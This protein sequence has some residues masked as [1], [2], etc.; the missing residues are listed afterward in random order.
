MTSGEEALREFARLELARIMS[1][2]VSE[3]PRRASTLGDDDPVVIKARR[4][5]LRSLDD[6]LAPVVPIRRAAS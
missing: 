6:R 4:D 3:P 1:G 5:V 2:T